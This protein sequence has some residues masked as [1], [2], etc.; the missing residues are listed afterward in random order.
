MAPAK[1]HSP[2]A[3]TNSITLVRTAR[4]IKDLAPRK[5]PKGGAS[6]KTV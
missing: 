1:P 5:K 3:R 2:G 6:R 4:P